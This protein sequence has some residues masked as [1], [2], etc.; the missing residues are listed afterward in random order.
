MGSAP[1]ARVLF[2]VLP[3]FR[4]CGTE[5]VKPLEHHRLL[6]PRDISN[7]LLCT[8]HLRIEALVRRGEL[9]AAT[10]QPVAL[11]DELFL[12]LAPQPLR[13]AAGCR[14]AEGKRCRGR[15]ELCAQERNAGDTGGDEN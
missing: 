4:E 3:V 10:V 14:D 7:G 1:S 13:S 9:I 2:E 6:M 15:S 11:R 12:V 5:T 8:V